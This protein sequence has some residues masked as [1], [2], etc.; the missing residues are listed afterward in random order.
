[1]FITATV[2]DGARRRLGVRRRLTFDNGGG[3]LRQWVWSFDGGNGGRGWQALWSM[4]TELQ[5]R[6]QCMTVRHQ[7][8]TTGIKWKT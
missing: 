5:Q 3:G 7:Q 2:Y 1:M 8:K 4:K 6:R